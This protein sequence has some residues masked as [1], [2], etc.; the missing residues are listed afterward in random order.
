MEF[1]TRRWDRPTVAEGGVNGRIITD[2]DYNRYEI[3]DLTVLDEDSRET[4][5]KFIYW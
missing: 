2:V 4:F 3:E 5:Y 1:M